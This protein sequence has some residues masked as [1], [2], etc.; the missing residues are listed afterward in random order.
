MKLSNTITATG[1]F[2]FQDMFISIK[3]LMLTSISLSFSILQAFSASPGA[4]K[5]IFRQK[6]RG[7]S[8]KLAPEYEGPEIEPF[9][10]LGLI[11][12]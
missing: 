7:L 2:I 6:S 5:K 3:M 8:K 1:L 12:H 11:L 10:L 4:N 9:A